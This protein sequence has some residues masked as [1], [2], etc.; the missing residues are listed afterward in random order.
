MTSI[1]FDKIFPDAYGANL[2]FITSKESIKQV[3]QLLRQEYPL[4]FLG[5][6]RNPLDEYLYITLSL[7][8]HEKG[9]K[10]AYGAFKQRFPSWKIAYQASKKEIGKAIVCGG[11]SKQKAANIKTALGQIHDRFGEVSLRELRRMDRNEAEAFLLTLPGVGLKSARCIMMYSL[12]YLVLPV[13]THVARISCRLG[14]VK[15]ADSDSIH[16][17]LEQLVE[18]KMRFSFHV[19]CVQHGRLVCRGKYPKCEECCL[20]RLCKKV[21]TCNQN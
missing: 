12:G 20:A 6:K 10:A 3:C 14:W 4:D 18:P 16:D 11:L 19:C 8:T 7:R 21:S 5:N 2:S 1:P 17:Q 9:L 15:K 13:D